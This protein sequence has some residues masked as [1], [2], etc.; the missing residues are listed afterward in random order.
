MSLRSKLKHSKVFILWFLNTDKLLV[1]KNSAVPRIFQPA[2]LYLESEE[3][4]LL[5]FELPHKTL[6]FT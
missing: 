5:V 6:Y 2:C 4:H 3:E 1:K